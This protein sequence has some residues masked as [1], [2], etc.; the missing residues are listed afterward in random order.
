VTDVG[1]GWMSGDWCWLSDVVTDVGWLI[2]TSLVS[3][4]TPQLIQDLRQTLHVS[5][6][7][8][9]LAYEEFKLSLATSQSV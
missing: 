2:Y 9:V 8:G 3:K 5:K 7:E 6:P 4:A 1:D